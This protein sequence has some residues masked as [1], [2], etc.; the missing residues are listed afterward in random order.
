MGVVTPAAGHL[1]L[2][3]ESRG[4][5]G[6]E[7]PAPHS[8]SRRTQRMLCDGDTVCKLALCPLGLIT[9]S[10]LWG[11]GCGDELASKIRVFFLTYFFNGG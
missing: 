8:P 6:D 1:G 9:T 11:L 3:R 10:A 5:P 2:R 7:V 4:L